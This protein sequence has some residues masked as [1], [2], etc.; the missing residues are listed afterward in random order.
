MS[1][2]IEQKRTRRYARCNDWL[3]DSRYR[4]GWRV[5]EYVQKTGVTF[6][7]ALLGIRKNRMGFVVDRRR[8]RNES[9]EV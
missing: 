3:S 6:F 2:T 8:I 1:L 7:R 9:K 5:S 4:H